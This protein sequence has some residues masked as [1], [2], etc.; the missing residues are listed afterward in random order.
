MSTRPQIANCPDAMTFRQW[1]YL[2]A[3]L[4]AYAR[5]QQVSAAGGK[6]EIADRIAHFLDTGERLKPARAPKPKSKVDWHS[7]SVTD[8]TIITDS[9]RNTQKV[10][11]YFASQIHGFALS[12]PLVTWIKAKVGKTMGYAVIEA[13]RLKA[14]K[15]Q[16]HQQP[17]Q[18]D[19]HYSA[20][21]RAYFA[22]V[23]DGSKAEVRAL[24][25]SRRARPGP[26]VFHLDD[27]TL[28]G[29]AGARR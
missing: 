8:A 7:T 26:Y 22:A 17:D 4:V 3:E 23:P 1:Y 12:I 27:L 29:R 15:A 13:N 21:T 25:A 20:Y 14:A 9:Y 5:A 18:P 16:G 19:T 10:R 11:R 24:W 6:S 2:K 28:N